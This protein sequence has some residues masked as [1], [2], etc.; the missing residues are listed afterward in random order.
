MDDN[1]KDTLTGGGLGAVIGGLAGGPVGATMG[2]AIG[3]LI[4]SSE[5]KHN[6]ALREA[7]YQI[8]DATDGEATYY[9]DHIDPKG[10]ESSG[11]QNVIDGISG[12]PD[13]ICIAQRYSNIV[14]EVETNEAIEDNSS[15]VI[16]QL[17]DFQTKGFKR[18]LVVPKSEVEDFKEWCEI[19]EQN[20][21][22]EQE[23]LLSTSETVGT[24]L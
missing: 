22:I 6:K 23:V 21:D 11:T 1:T 19:H 18:V 20:G 16:Q 2:G 13:I 14:V 10:A 7:Y 9:V 17:N 4:G 8:H 15:H 3:A 24:V 5:R 12:A